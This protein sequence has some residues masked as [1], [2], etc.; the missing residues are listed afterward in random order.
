MRPF[1]QLFFEKVNFFM[2]FLHLIFMFFLLSQKFVFKWLNDLARTFGIM[3]TE[4]ILN[5]KVRTVLSFQLVRVFMWPFDDWGWSNFAIVTNEGVSLVESS[6]FLFFVLNLI[7]RLFVFFYFFKVLVVDLLQFLDLTVKWGHFLLFELQFFDKVHAFL[8]FKGTESG[9]KGFLHGKGKSGLSGF[10]ELHDFAYEFFFEVTV[11]DYT[12]EKFEDFGDF[13]HGG[14]FGDI[15]KV[16]I[17]ILDALLMFIAEEFF[18]L[19][20]EYFPVFHFEH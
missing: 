1:L 6:D 2:Q 9:F 14:I 10:L 19:F 5:L 13:F 11:G 15:N 4:R 8:G 12:E 17:G 3:K 18:D 7:C 20:Q 16:D